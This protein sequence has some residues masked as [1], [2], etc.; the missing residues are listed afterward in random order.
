MVNY[1]AKVQRNEIP[2]YMSVHLVGTNAHKMTLVP[3]S[4]NLFG[5]T[6]HHSFHMP[7]GDQV[8]KV[9]S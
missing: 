7:C 6:T 9:G 5:S 8:N 1:Q 4:S 2:K 3:P